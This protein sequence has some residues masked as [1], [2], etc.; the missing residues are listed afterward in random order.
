MM[1]MVYRLCINKPRYKHM[2]GDMGGFKANGALGNVFTTN[3][4]RE[5]LLHRASHCIHK[6]FGDKALI[7]I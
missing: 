3:E 1:I 5:I 2:E 4:Y 7:D 6:G